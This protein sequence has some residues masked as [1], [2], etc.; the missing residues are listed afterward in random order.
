MHCLNVCPSPAVHGTTDKV[1]Y[2]SV[3]TPLTL[4]P[5]SPEPLKS[6]PFKATIQVCKVGVIAIFVKAKVDVQ[7]CPIHLCVQLLIR[8]W[9]S[10]WQQDVFS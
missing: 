5:L 1:Q 3:G 2:M 6:K 4:R 9:H 8:Q 7:S 10:V